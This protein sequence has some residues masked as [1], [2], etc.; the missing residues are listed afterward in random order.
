MGETGFRAT[1]AVLLSFSDPGY[2]SP[3]YASDS[4]PPLLGVGG[5]VLSTPNSDTFVQTVTLQDS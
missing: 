5:F 3:T 2:E 4:P 1:E